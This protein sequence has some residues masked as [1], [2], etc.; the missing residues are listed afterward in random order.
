MTTIATYN[1]ESDSD[2]SAL[3]EA[4]KTDEWLQSVV[5]NF[6]PGGNWCVSDG[7]GGYKKDDEGRYITEGLS[8]HGLENYWKVLASLEA[9]DEAVAVDPDPEAYDESR[10]EPE[11]GEDGITVVESA[12]SYDVKNASWMLLKMAA[13][14]DEAEA[15]AR[16]H[17][18]CGLKYGL[19]VEPTQ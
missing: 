13:T 5:R 19:Y 4:C 10:D 11:G 9:K 14:E 6:S 16:D 3:I 8:D 12:Q 7:A 17:E 15:W 1:L 18:G 2:V